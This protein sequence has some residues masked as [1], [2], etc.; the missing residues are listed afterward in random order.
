MKRRDSEIENKTGGLMWTKNELKAGTFSLS[1]VF[2]VLCALFPQKLFAGRQ[3]LV[4]GNG[5][6][7]VAALRNPVNDA[8]DISRVLREVGF[9]VLTV[10]D[11][12]PKEM[13]QAIKQF[14]AQVTRDDV[15][16]FYF[17]GH[18]VQFNN[19]NYLLPVD[20]NIESE[21]IKLTTAMN[22]FNKADISIIIIDACRN[23]P[24]N[25]FYQT[26]DG[27]LTRSSRGLG[28][29]VKKGL[30]PPKRSIESFVA[31]STDIGNVAEDGT[32]RN[33]TFTKYL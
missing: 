18:A 22:T 17:A 4:I 3:A 21:A 19:E 28:I 26:I 31:Y 10:L 25:I 16:L 29:H 32:G 11:G 6:Y 7:S 9:E 27:E 5:N 1:I 20:A 14:S 15:A 24:G 13:N 23:N 33:S 8:T 30:A 12:S 2:V